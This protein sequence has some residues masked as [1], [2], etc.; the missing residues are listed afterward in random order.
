MT[1]DIDW[2]PSIFD[3]DIDDVE[4]FFDTKEDIISHGPFDQYEEY[5][6]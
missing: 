1:V 5:R 3:N 6:Y 2:N 4:T